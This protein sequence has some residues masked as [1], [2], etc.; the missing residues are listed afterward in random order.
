MAP[1]SPFEIHR[2]S[3]SRDVL[4]LKTLLFEGHPEPFP[5]APEYESPTIIQSALWYP[6]E[7]P[8]VNAKVMQRP[9]VNETDAIVGMNNKIKSG[10]TDDSLG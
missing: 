5:I 9:G 2:Q 3:Q 10:D 7:R 4:Y 6:I 8:N 1:H